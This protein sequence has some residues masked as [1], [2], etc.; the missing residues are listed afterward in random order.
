MNTQL[1]SGPKQNKRR[2]AL[3]A[4]RPPGGAKN[5]IDRELDTATEACEKGAILFGAVVVVAVIVELGIA[6]LHPPYDSSLQKWGSSAT[7]AFIAIGIVGEVFFGMVQTRLQTEI[8]RRSDEKVA[9]ATARAAEA[10]ERASQADLARTELEAQLSPRMLNQEQW[11]LIQSIKGKFSA[12]NIGFETDAEAWW[13]A[14]QLKNAFRSV[15]IKGEM[16]SRDPSVHSFG[17]LIF[18][19][20]GFD[21][22]RPRTVEPLVKLFKPENQLR[23]GSAAIITGLPEDVLQQ[24]GDNEEARSQLI[25]TPM[26]IVGGRFIVPPDHWPKPPRQQRAP[27]K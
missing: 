23:Y 5:A 19:P 11:D 6:I 8:R 25:Q 1:T 14:G 20:K 4:W 27:E 17:I 13:F 3:V 16:L 18:D 24:A 10:N 26:I 15:G 2:N 21:E 12:I 7:D 22:S 9:E